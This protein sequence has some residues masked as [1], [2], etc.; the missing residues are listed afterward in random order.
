MNSRRLAT[1]TLLALAV[2]T[3]FLALPASAQEAKV[4]L[5]FLDFGATAAETV[6]V[7]LDGQMLRLAA[8]YL[9]EDPDDAATA[10]LVSGLS[11][12]YVR[13]FVFDDKGSYSKGDVDRVRKQLGA[14]WSRI[15]TSRSRD[16]EDVEIWVRSKNDRVAGLVIL[17]AE[18]QELTVVNLV[19]EID[20]EKLSSLENQFGIPKLGLEE[21]QAASQ[22]ARK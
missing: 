8:K 15:V 20:L 21:K 16:G 5:S 10:R 1:D 19:G 13:S 2:A 3:L 7:T 9:A 6:E 11:G 14:G 17:A 4:D 18:P 12:I 22:G